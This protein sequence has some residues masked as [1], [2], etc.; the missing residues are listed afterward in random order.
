ML[1]LFGYSS[2]KNIMPLLGPDICRRLMS[3]ETLSCAAVVLG[4]RHFLYAWS[5]LQ[6]RIGFVSAWPM[7]IGMEVIL[8][9]K[10]LP[11]CCY[12]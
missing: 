6:I 4:S 5:F 2:L 8:N 3:E 1:V 9:E 11:Y 7:G 10:S 12:K